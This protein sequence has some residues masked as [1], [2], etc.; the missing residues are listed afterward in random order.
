MRVLTK[1]E[2]EKKALLKS[3]R[4]AIRLKHTLRAD[5]EIGQRL[6]EI[7]A[8]IDAALLTGKPLAFTVS[9]LFTDNASGA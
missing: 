2:R 7:E 8:K 3:A 6:P 1:H 4:Q 5:D 9:S